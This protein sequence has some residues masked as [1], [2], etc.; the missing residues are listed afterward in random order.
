MN[1]WMV[2]YEHDHKKTLLG[3]FSSK[4]KALDSIEE[5]CGMKP[6]F[7]DKDYWCPIGEEQYWDRVFAG[8][9]EP[10]VGTYQ[11]DKIRV[12]QSTSLVLYTE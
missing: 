12:N 9:D 1:V 4:Q 6:D 2:T 5:H 7:G 8:G 3:I 11:L 10:G